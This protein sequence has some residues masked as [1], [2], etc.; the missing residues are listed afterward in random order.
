MNGH[1]GR[2][3]VLHVLHVLF[4]FYYYSYWGA[5]GNL[6]RLLLEHFRW[7]TNWMARVHS[8]RDWTRLKHKLSQQ[9]WVQN[10]LAGGYTHRRTSLFPISSGGPPPT[11]AS[12]R[13]RT[14]TPGGKPVCKSRTAM[15]MTIIYCIF[16]SC[17][18]V[19][20]LSS[21]KGHSEYRRIQ[22]AVPSQ[23]LCK[24]RRAHLLH[25]W[26]RTTCHAKEHELGC[27]RQKRKPWILSTLI[28]LV[29]L[30]HWS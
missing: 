24:D 13:L 30:R 4:F 12:T 1:R 8:F 11:P 21:L 10:N 26:V 3:S 7:N 20:S 6:L 16:F 2:S 15:P 25:N 17:I 22:T 23:P 18:S 5:G 27:Y 9:T 19:C 14:L 29:C 28:C